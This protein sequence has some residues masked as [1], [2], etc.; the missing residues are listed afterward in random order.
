MDLPGYFIQHILRLEMQMKESLVL[1]NICL[2][3]RGLT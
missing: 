2:A 3:N 1:S